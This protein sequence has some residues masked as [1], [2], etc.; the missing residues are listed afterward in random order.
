MTALPRAVQGMPP[1]TLRQ[2]FAKAFVCG[3]ALPWVKPKRHDWKHGR[4]AQGPVYN[5]R[6]CTRTMGF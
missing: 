3:D 2:R 1:Y 6:R 4:G 5:C